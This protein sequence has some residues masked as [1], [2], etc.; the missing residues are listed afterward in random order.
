M[1]SDTDAGGLTRRD[2]IGAAYQVLSN[3][4]L[5]KQYDRFGPEKAVPDSGF[6]AISVSDH[7]YGA[8]D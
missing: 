3:T 2:Q 1:S 7:P 5:R 8:S 6:G 4:D